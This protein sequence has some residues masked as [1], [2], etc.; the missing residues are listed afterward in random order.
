[1]AREAADAGIKLVVVEI[2]DMTL[3]T[4]FVD[5]LRIFDDGRYVRKGISLRYIYPARRTD[6]SDLQDEEGAGPFA[7]LCSR[8]SASS[9][10][11]VQIHTLDVEYQSEHGF[12]TKRFAAYISYRSEELTSTYSNG[13]N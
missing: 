8:Y 6:L 4:C 9:V 2:D 10:L 7:F 5:E 1:V 12:K 11:Q 13:H 3:V